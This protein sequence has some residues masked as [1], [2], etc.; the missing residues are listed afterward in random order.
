[1]K[2]ILLTV[3]SAAMVFTWVSAGFCE[4]KVQA[5]FE[6]KCSMCHSTDRPKGKKMTPKQW[7]STV[8]RMRT[9]GCPLTDD[10]AKSIVDYLSKHYGK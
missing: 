2:K 9:N 6:K 4:D 7:E 8:K 3:L 5:L 1:M 10:E